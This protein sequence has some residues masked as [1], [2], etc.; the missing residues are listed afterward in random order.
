MMS[1][2][3]IHDI[4]PLVEIN[5]YSFYLFS[6]FIVI[7]IMALSLIIYLVYKMFQHRKKDI[8]KEYFGILQNIDW[9]DSKQTAYIITKYGFLLVRTPLEEESLQNLVRKLEPYKYKKN[10]PA[11]DSKT[12]ALFEIFMDGL[13]V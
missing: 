4:K 9:T 7:I 13:S 6:S 5:D 10:V 1:D 2:L 8:R 12:Q 3:K 11:V